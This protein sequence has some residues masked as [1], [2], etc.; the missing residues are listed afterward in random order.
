MFKNKQQIAIFMSFCALLFTYIVVLVTAKVAIF[1]LRKYA[2]LFFLF[3]YL[4]TFAPA[5]AEKRRLQPA[6]NEVCRNIL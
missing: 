5:K 1:C 4:T 3:P 2:P 6:L